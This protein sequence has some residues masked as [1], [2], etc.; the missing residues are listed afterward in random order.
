M[1]ATMTQACRLAFSAAPVRIVEPVYDC[2]VIATAESIGQAQAVLAQRRAKIVGQDM[3]EG[4]LLYEISAW[5]PVV[6]SLS[7]WAKET[8][9]EKAAA[10]RLGGSKERK[11]VRPSFAD[12]LRKSTSGVASAQ[13]VFSHWEPIDVDPFWVPTTKDEK[14]DFGEYD[15]EGA[16][17]LARKYIDETRRRK[18][19]WVEEKIVEKAD[20][21]RNRSVKK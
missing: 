11:L 3:R 2:R 18:G 19:L 1:I 9:A 15:R 10:K 16:G 14:E 21:Q 20:K 6:E 12:E 7:T 5:L 17:N 13:L 8:E 4:S